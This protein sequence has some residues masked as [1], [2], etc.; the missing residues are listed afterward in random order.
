VGVAAADEN[1]SMRAGGMA[2]GGEVAPA[3]LH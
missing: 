2:H 3:A 1:E